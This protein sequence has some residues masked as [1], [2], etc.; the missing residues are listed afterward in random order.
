M[1]VVSVHFG[2]YEHPVEGKLFSIKNKKPKQTKTKTRTKKISTLN[3]IFLN[4]WFHNGLKRGNYQLCLQRCP[5]V[6]NSCCLGSLAYKNYIMLLSVVY[7][8]LFIFVLI[9]ISITTV[10]LFSLPQCSSWWKWKKKKKY[11]GSL[12]CMPKS[13]S[14]HLMLLVQAIQV[15]IS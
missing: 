8:V 7:C 12:I 10:F 14:V 6:S 3:I 11:W 1:L 13:L 4:K 15:C 9:W 5:P 2:D